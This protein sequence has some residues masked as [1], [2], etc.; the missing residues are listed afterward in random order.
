MSFPTPLENKQWWNPGSWFL[1]ASTLSFASAFIF[2]FVILFVYFGEN[3]RALF[4]LPVYSLPNSIKP[5]ILIIISVLALVI[6]IYITLVTSPRPSR[7]PVKMWSLFMVVLSGLALWVVFSSVPSAWDEEWWKWTSFRHTLL[8]ASFMGAIT[9]TPRLLKP[10]VDSRTIQ[11]ITPLTL[12]LL[13]PLTALV[14]SLGNRVEADQRDL[15]NDTLQALQNE[16]QTLKEYSENDTSLKAKTIK[17]KSLLDR[18]WITPDVLKNAS[19]MA[20]SNLGVDKDTANEIEKE[21][22]RIFKNISK[23][24]D[25]ENLPSIYR[26]GKAPFKYLGEEGW[27]LDKDTQNENNEIADYYRVLD[28]YLAKRRQELEKSPLANKQE[29]LKDL[30]SMVAS[31]REKLDDKFNNW[32]DHWL[33][34]QLPEIFPDKEYT[35]DKLLNDLMEIP[36]FEDKTLSVYGGITRI[37]SN[38]GT[39]NALEDYAFNNKNCF[40][41]SKDKLKKGSSLFRCYAYN[42][43]SSVSVN[44]ILE[45]RVQVT[46]SKKGDY[47]I[48]LSTPLLEDNVAISSQSL[49]SRIKA[50][51]QNVCKEGTQLSLKSRSKT[52][53]H[54]N[55]NKVTKI[56]LKYTKKCK[57]RKISDEG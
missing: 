48:Y 45:Y 7:L 37:L 35:N 31:L 11:Y 23:L 34:Y 2:V 53:P 30:S 42:G 8:L 44:V 41:Y 17:L 26:K 21:L 50:K 33:V 40:F 18:P 22:S 5:Y 27:E 15:V 9:L 19:Y 55:G 28:N 57:Q 54:Y 56:E 38:S 10:R 4:S 13:V 25:N 12:L 1:P 43:N 24:N 3:L 39:D 20:D 32:M 29:K 47:R 14:I 16:N 6:S 46:N 36:V 49:I 51:A 52:D